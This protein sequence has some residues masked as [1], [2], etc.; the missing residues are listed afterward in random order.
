MKTPAFPKKE[1]EAVLVTIFMNV[2]RL[3]NRNRF[4]F[5]G[6]KVFIGEFFLVFSFKVTF[7]YS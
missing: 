7:I 2:S 1:A 5:W 3:S 6:W 4:I